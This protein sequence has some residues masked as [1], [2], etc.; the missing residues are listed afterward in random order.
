[1]LTSCQGG[2]MGRRAVLGVFAVALAGCAVLPKHID[3]PVSHAIADAHD[4]ALA[5]L[6]APVA[7]QHPR[8]SGFL[9]YNTGEGAIQARVALAAVAAS[10]IDAQYYEW[11]GDALGR[12]VLEQV[13]AAADR[14]V[15]VRLL[16]DDYAA[17]GHD[18]AFEALDAHANIEV[19]VFNSYV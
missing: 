15:R 6:V 3:R 11:A 4:S 16:I 10:T 2:R 14:G 18:I 17:K 19:L 9:L 1:M 8:D 5:R 12:A 13:L 7:A